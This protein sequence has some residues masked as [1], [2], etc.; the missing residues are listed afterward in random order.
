MSRRASEWEQ[1]GLDLPL[2]KDAASTFHHRIPSPRPS[3]ERDPVTM[4]IP[5]LLVVLLGPRHAEAFE[6]LAGGHPGLREIAGLHPAELRSY[7]LTAH[8]VE[9]L[10]ALFEV[11]K[12]YGQEEFVPGAPFRGSADV[13][14]H[15]RE[16]LADEVVEHFYVILLDNKHRKLRDCEVSLGSL[17]SS[18]VH[19]RDVFLTVIRHSA[20]AVIFVHNHPSGDPTPSQEDLALTRRLREVGELIGVRVLDHIIIGKGRYVSFVDDGYW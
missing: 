13:Y 6:R 16:R 1:L 9:K 15:F 2:V 5:E 10:S 18:V 19:P 11:A 14:A 7:G 4:T 3:L 12:R 8:A 17:T 20:A